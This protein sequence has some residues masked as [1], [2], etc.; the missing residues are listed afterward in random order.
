MWD[1]AATQR[2]LPCP[3]L[4]PEFCAAHL[5]S[6]G[7]TEPAAEGGRIS[8]DREAGECDGRGKKQR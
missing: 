5:P 6:Q 1:V 3:A 8:L 2:A 7:F 4:Q